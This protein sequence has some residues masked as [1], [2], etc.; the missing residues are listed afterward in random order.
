MDPT[1]ATNPREITVSREK[2]EVHIRWQDGHESVY[3][4]DLL[5]RECPCALC[6]D[7]RSKQ[8]A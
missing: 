3:G 7:E 4:F 6:N 8:A 2:R 1:I 5:R